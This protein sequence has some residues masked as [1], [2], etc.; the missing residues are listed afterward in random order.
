M[1]SSAVKSVGTGGRAPSRVGKRSVTI[2]L[3][4]DAVKQLRSIGVNED[5][6]L[7]DLMIE[8]VNMLFKGR[9][10]AETAK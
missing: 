9:G 6:T 3:E 8:A 10:K 4:L 2:Y 1:Q 5:H 7:Q